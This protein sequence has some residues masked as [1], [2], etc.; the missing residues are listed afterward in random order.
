MLEAYSQNI[1]VAVNTALPL[2]NTSIVK[3]CTATKSDVSTIALNKCGVYL[4]S[5]D[6]TAA[7]S[8]TAGNVSVQLSKDGVIQPQAITSTASTGTTDIESLSFVT[9]VQVS[10]NNT[11]DCCTSPVIIRFIN[12]GVAATFT[13]ANVVVTKI[14]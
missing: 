6:A 14:C 12:T 2:N 4:V 11:C 9:L 5:F 13:Q 1:S 8:A 7:T 3:G 10:E